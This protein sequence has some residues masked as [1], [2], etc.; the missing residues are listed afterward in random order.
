MSTISSSNQ[1]LTM[2]DNSDFIPVLTVLPER[3]PAY[4]WIVRRPDQGGVGPNLC[5]LM[6]WD[7]RFPMSY[8]LWQKFS[9]WAVEFE[10]VCSE[11]GFS[12]DVDDDWDWL[13]FHARG[14]HLARWLK[15][16]VGDSYRVVYYKPYQ[17]P[18]HT[19]DER[20]EILTDG[21][22]LPLEPFDGW[23]GFNPKRFCQ[24]IVSGGQTGADRA[25]LDFAIENG[26]THGGW[27]PAGRQAED[28]AIPLKYQLTVLPDGGY[29]ARTRRNVEDSDGTLIFNL[30]ELDGG[31]LAT[32]QF[33]EVLGKPYLV[34]KVD[35]GVSDDTLAGLIGWLCE[36]N[37][38]TLNVA[39]PRESKRPGIYALT[40]QLL[41]SVH[42]RVPKVIDVDGMPSR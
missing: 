14:M 10:L 25:A 12:N 9:D 11:A 34:V 31:T 21:S 19:L 30:G 36:H 29:R 2:S 28:G 3:G 20:T 39:G 1:A 38:R 17:D 32:K 42:A 35:S 33:A 37:L 16:E 13:A 41:S 7:D 6:G 24:H 15:E 8:G 22:L 27:A 40:R 18:N 4:I 5:D 26:Y 23:P